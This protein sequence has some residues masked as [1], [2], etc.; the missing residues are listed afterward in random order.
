MSF[1]VP[2]G[3]PNVTIATRTA[4]AVTFT[5]TVITCSE[6]NGFITGYQRVG[7]NS[8]TMIAPN[9]IFTAADLTPATTYIFRVA[10]VSINGTGPFST[11]TTVTTEEAREQ[12]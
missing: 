7:M 8:G 9:Q 12:T 4:R 1:L 3:T 5:W 6:R 10:G 2:T 11:P